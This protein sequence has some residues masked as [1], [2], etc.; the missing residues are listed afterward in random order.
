MIFF[1]QCNLIMVLLQTNS[2]YIFPTSFCL[3]S[4]FNPKCLYRLWFW[5][6][7]FKDFLFRWMHVRMYVCVHILNNFVF[8]L[9]Y[10]IAL[11]SFNVRFIKFILQ[12]FHFPFLW[13]IFKTLMVFLLNFVVEFNC[14]YF[15]AWA[16]RTG[17]LFIAVSIA[18]SVNSPV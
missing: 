5:F 11:L 12:F 16:I 9:Y 13:N 15:C 4:L 8:K 18:L 1:I 3:F 17:N 14:E 7:V 10:Y 2:S 6:C